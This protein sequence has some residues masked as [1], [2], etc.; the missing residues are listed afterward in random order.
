MKISLGTAYGLHA[1]MFMVRHA[2]QLPITAEGIAKAEGIPLKYLAKILHRLA[3]ACI[4]KSSSGKNKGYSFNRNPKEITLLEVFDTIE[5]K[6][7]FDGCFMQRCKCS[8]TP[9]NCLIYAQ[10]LNATKR[11]AK[12]LS[13]TNIESAAWHHPE[14]RFYKISK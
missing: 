14:H 4:I 2:T 3:K 8:G 12:F 6:P 1:L 10:W 11:I 13:E 7:I 9:Q 5:G